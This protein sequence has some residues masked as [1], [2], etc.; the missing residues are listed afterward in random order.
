MNRLYA[1]SR[2]RNCDDENTETETETDRERLF[3][4][5]GIGRKDGRATKRNYF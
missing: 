3:S 2:E 4:V 1:S 5:V